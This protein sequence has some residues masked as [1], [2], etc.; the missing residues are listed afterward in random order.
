MS[1]PLTVCALAAAKKLPPD[2]LLELGLRDG[3][4]GV[5]MPYL[6]ND[7]RELFARTRLSL[8]GD[9]RF[10][11]AAGVSLQ[12]YGLNR[13]S[14]ARAKGYALLVEGESDCWASWFHDFPAIGLPGASA[15]KAL[16]N[17][18]LQGIDKIFAY[19]EPDRGGET[20]IEGIARRLDEIRYPGE[21]YTIQ[22]AGMK[23]IADLHVECADEPA[24]FDVVLTA[25][26]HH[27]EVLSPNTAGR[28]PSGFRTV[29]EYLGEA[30]SRSSKKSFWDRI[31]REG[32][33]SLLVG[34]A[35]AGKSTFA[36]ALARAVT[37]G[38]PLLG[39][40]CFQAKIGYMA[41]ERNGL[42]VARLFDKWSLSGLHFLDELP[43]M[44]LPELAKFL[45]EQIRE[46]GLELLMVDHL[47]NLTKVRDSK[48]YS[49]VSIALEP[50]QRLAKSTGAHILLLH[51]QGKTE[52][53]GVIDVMGSEAYRAGADALIEAKKYGGQYFIRAEIRGEAD[54]PK[55][56]VSINLSTGEVAAVD[57]AQAE[58]QDATTK[59]SNYLNEQPEPLS[60]DAIQEALELKRAV[61]RAA[62]NAGSEDG[63]FARTGAGRK[64]EPFLYSVPATDQQQRERNCENTETAYAENDLFRSRDDGNGKEP[65]P[66]GSE[67]RTPGTA[68]MAGTESEIEVIE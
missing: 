57:A 9:R 52:R 63:T 55:T 45:E 10:R 7:G 38:D 65:N 29:R 35:L 17:E 2:F 30:R 4:E 61:V 56:R 68:G 42:A 18:H 16:Q 47:Q 66:E 22:I 37:F 27:A 34:R 43:V 26:L 53:E 58:M 36:C 28:R 59:I 12:P 3:A 49:L 48:D 67:A 11:Q 46:H 62:L 25:A 14:A 13:L 54:L 32:E 60:A 44:P 23:D 51:H 41:L 20:F 31:L 24:A 1:P 6:D 5:E 33:V 39:R 64:G 8:D 19:R 50:L 15:A 40:E 21:T